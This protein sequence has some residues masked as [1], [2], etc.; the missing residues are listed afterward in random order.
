MFACASATCERAGST[1]RTSS[2][3]GQTCTTRR[4][5]PRTSPRPNRRTAIRAAP[6]PAHR[7]PRAAADAALPP[8]AVLVASPDPALEPPPPPPF[9]PPS[10]PEGSRVAPPLVPLSFATLAKAADPGVVTIISRI[11]EVR[12][13]GRR[14]VVQE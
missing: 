14:R 6:R 2:D 3:T 8:G 5:M 13:G 11:E 9:V 12:P 7:A 1:K 4:P 10:P